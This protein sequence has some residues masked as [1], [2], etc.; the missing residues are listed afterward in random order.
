MVTNI[1]SCMN[2][3]MHVAHTQKKELKEFPLLWGV[4]VAA[5]FSKPGK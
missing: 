4:T 3:F 2:F 1:G 5:F